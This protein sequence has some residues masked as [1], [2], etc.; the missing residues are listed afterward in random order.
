MQSISVVSSQNQF[1]RFTFCSY[2]LINDSV[3]LVTDEGNVI[4]YFLESKY[5]IP[6][7]SNA[8]IAPIVTIINNSTLNQ[9]ILLLTDTVP[10]CVSSSLTPY[11]T[12]LPFKPIT[13]S[14][15]PT[16]FHFAI[17]DGNTLS[18]LDS[19]FQQLYTSPI[20]SPIKFDWRSDGKYLSVAQSSSISIFPYPF[21]SPI[22]LPLSSPCC[23]WRPAVGML[24]AI[25]G[26]Q[27]QFYEPGGQ[28]RRSLKLDCFS[29]PPKFI[30]FSLD[31]VV[32]MVISD[33][34]VCFY[35]EV[36]LK[37]YLKKKLLLRN[38]TF[39]L[40]SR[41]KSNLLLSNDFIYETL[42][43]FNHSITNINHPC[44]QLVSQNGNS[45]LSVSFFCS[46]PPPP[47]SSLVVDLDGTLLTSYT[48]PS[49]G[50]LYVVLES[51]FSISL[52]AFHLISQR[53]RR[54]FLHSFEQKEA[55]C[56]DQ[57][58][59]NLIDLVVNQV[60]LLLVGNIV[61]LL[62]NLNP[63]H[64]VKEIV[65]F[66]S[67][68][69]LTHAYGDVIMIAS[70]K[71]VVVIRVNQSVIGSIDKI[72]VES[73]PSCLSDNCLSTVDGSLI[74]FNFDPSFNYKVFT[75][76]CCGRV[77]GVVSNGNFVSF[78][79]PLNTLETRALTHVDYDV[80]DCAPGLFSRSIDV[81]AQLITV[82]PNQIDI[83]FTSPY[84]NTTRVRPLILTLI[85]CNDLIQKESSVFDELV[86]GLLFGQ[87]VRLDL[88]FVIDLYSETVSN[89]VSQ[90]ITDYPQLWTFTLETLRN[91]NSFEENEAFY[92]CL[93]LFTQ[94]LHDSRF[95]STKVFHF[96]SKSL[97]FLESLDYGDLFERMTLLL[98]VCKLLKTDYYLPLKTINHSICQSKSQS[99]LIDSF[100]SSFKLVTGSDSADVLIN[101]CFELQLFDLA[102]LIAVAC[103]QDPRVFSVEISRLSS[104][105]CTELRLFEIFKVTGKSLIAINH[106][107]DYLNQS[108][109][110]DKFFDVDLFFKYVL[111]C[112]AELKLFRLKSNEL[113][114]KFVP[115]LL[116]KYEINQDFICVCL[117]HGLPQICQELLIK[118]GDWKTAILLRP[119]LM[120]NDA[121]LQQI[122]EF[123]GPMEYGRLLIERSVGEGHFKHI[124]DTALSGSNQLNQSD[125]IDLFR[126]SRFLDYS[127]DKIKSLLIEKT[128]A[129]FDSN[130]KLNVNKITSLIDRINRTRELIKSGLPKQHLE[131][132]RKNKKKVDPKNSL[133]KSF[134]KLKPML[135]QESHLKQFFSNLLLL[136]II[137]EHQLAL[138]LFEHLKLSLKSIESLF[139]NEIVELLD[140]TFVLSFNSVC[141]IF[142]SYYPLVFKLAFDQ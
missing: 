140:G 29:S 26:D 86:S 30:C 88:N 79:S 134:E 39:I 57:L 24:S 49:S 7:V 84:G 82:D 107:I 5:F 58:Q 8:P 89:H 1:P 92:G 16:G 125:L 56:I 36:N 47:V 3:Y 93:N 35:M 17:A 100:V 81:S 4:Q 45:Q 22:H 109:M 13:A 102:G 121:F 115:K 129:H 66:S 128:T 69:I 37:W 83:I 64:L 138:Q 135:I 25:V 48:C 97:E 118:I 33:V 141:E 38:Q 94:E 46:L 90:L 131:S 71:E 96:A 116:E 50:D 40:P 113:K 14:S 59:S 43:Y 110:I 6:I 65:S 51:H 123:A 11:H 53:K 44:G 114:S 80:S 95:W 10:L 87:R 142:S 111:D 91:S 106:A 85:Q 139:T 105:D 119:E 18:I 34:E 23:S 28:F 62:E 31:G 60:C 73:D 104:I 126:W 32:M 12:T 122:L 55:I 67:P 117:F 27:L 68:I 72:P 130:L 99:V 52:V 9:D 137:N 20:T 41:F 54:K 15:S 108:E 124:I 21:T 2:S 103:G 76:I 77:C 112:E 70:K 19:S 132:K 61:Y 127:S 78:I 63:E 101:N 74:T 120:L 42:P 136:V 98:T 133:S 75:K